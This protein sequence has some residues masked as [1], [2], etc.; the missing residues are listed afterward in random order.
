MWAMVT[1][2]LAGAAAFL[3]LKGQDF[4]MQALYVSGFA[5]LAFA[6]LAWA[7]GASRAR[8]SASRL[9]RAAADESA[10]GLLMMAA[11]GRFV[12]TNASFHRLFRLAAETASGRV[13]SLEAIQRALAGDEMAL[14]AFQRLA[15]AA[16]AGVARHEEFPIS[17][18]PGSL[19][20]RRLTVSPVTRAGHVSDGPGALWR[21]ED[22]TAS[23]EMDAVRR[24]EETH[25][26]DFLDLLPVGF[27]SADP[28]G[29]FLYVNQ[30]LAQW[31]GSSPEEMVTSPLDE[32][33]SPGED[34][35]VEAAK[36]A[37]VTFKRR[38]GGRFKGWVAQ[39][40]HAGDADRPAYSRCVVLRSAD[41]QY[42]QP[43][44]GDGQGDGQDDGQGSPEIRLHW[45]FDEAPVGIVLLDLQGNIAECNRAFLK[46][47]GLNPE[48]LI[49]RTFADRVAKEDR[50]DIAA[51]L[52]KVVMGT[53]RATHMEIRMPGAGER[54]LVASLYASRLEDAMGEI[55]GLALHF[56]DTTE[57]R[58]LE[59]QFAQSQKME[60]IGQ[61]AGGVAHD[62]N[63]LLTAMIGFSDLLLTR[64]GPDDPSF[65]DIQQI[66]QNANRATDLVRQLLAFSRKQA[67]ALVALDVTETLNELTTLLG[68]LIGE[69]IDLS[70]EHG[71][72]LAPIKVDR[73]Q[74]DQVIINLAVNGRD[75]MPGGGQLT[76][77][78]SALTLDAPVQR[79]HDLMPKGPYILIEV[80]DTG[81]GIR[82]ENIEKIFEPFFSTKEVGAGTGLGLSTVYGIV[83]QCGG[84]IYVDSAPGEG[85]TFSIYMPEYTED[86]EA[87]DRA[88][89]MDTRPPSASLDGAAAALGDLTGSGTVLLVE[90]EDAVR[91]FGARALRNKGYTVL[92]AENGEGA[93]DVINATD[94]PIDLIISDVV[95]PGMDG[96]TL[97]GLV[98][99]ELPDVKVILMSGYAEDVFRDEIDRDPSI[100]FLSKPFSLKGLARTVKEVMAG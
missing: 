83:H 2:M 4:S 39:S 68:R 38:D 24:E 76:I 59:V 57:Q 96:H 11:N 70:L 28:G 62:F 49:G 92:E 82:K 3:H 88:A 23:R 51:A 10:E 81:T 75:A 33:M 40:L 53:A 35:R 8:D 22:I 47:T 91:L 99:H 77:R 67:L 93:L 1:V 16:E 6:G 30:T 58:N 71:G 60:A 89:G 94:G 21:A 97:I 90:D 12:Y 34:R 73:G 29:R 64:H 31:L 44:L 74:F 17:T 52:S 43:G 48:D 18:V 32:Y 56:I 85:T 54:E 66:R 55:S 95:M 45:L 98:R 79:G 25:L 20:W 41:W 65:A 9:L 26:A 80:S 63:N 84:F 19:E 27:F 86:A 7:L 36:A 42:R 15:A 87:Q 5:L 37:T 72:D 100:E 13:T 78:T 69:K 46:L 50:G 61:L 14:A